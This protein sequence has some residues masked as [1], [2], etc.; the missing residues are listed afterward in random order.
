MPYRHYR[1][2]THN[3]SLPD[4]EEFNKL[5][6]DELDEEKLHEGT[7]FESWD[8][9]LDAI[10]VYARRCGFRLRKGRID[11]T[12]DGVIRKRTVL[13]EHS[14]E[15]KPR[16]TLV[17]K[18]STKYIKCQ[19]H[20]N[21]SQP[22]QNNP[23]GNV[24]VTTIKNEHN[25]ELSSFRVEFLDNSMLTQQML[26][27]IEFYV[28]DVGL[29][30][31]Q[32]Q[33]ALQKEFPD[34]EIY[35]PE[36]HKVMA[37]FHHKKRTDISNDAASLYESLLKRKDNDPRW[38]IAIDWDRET[39]CLRR[40]FWMSPE[41]I[42]LWMEFGDIILNDNTAKTNRYDMALS[43]FL[44]IDNHGSSRL[45]GCAL[46]DDES[47]DAH[48][49][50][51]HQ[52]KQATGNCVP[53]VIMTDADPALDLAIAEEYEESYAMHCIFHIAQNLPRNLET[54]LGEQ[55]REFVKDFY[56]TRNALVPEIFECKWIQLI[57]KYNQPE[58]VR[59]LQRTLYSSKRAWARAYTATVFTAGIQTTSRIESYN[60]QIKR[61]ILNS[62]V[63]LLELAE[64]L[65]RSMNEESKRAKYKYWKT[66]F[67]STSSATLSQTLF[68]KLDETLCHFLTPTM[69]KVQ[70]AEI[71][72]CL[73]YQASAITQ[74]DIIEYQE[75]VIVILRVNSY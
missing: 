69:L 47:A 71:K 20:V 41:Q 67:P 53:A 19:W 45:V 65:E 34:R 9:A 44:C 6:L 70:C 28:N 7:V 62:N 25:H 15:Y 63:S 42:I 40:L 74:E 58:V 23:H 55:Y 75:V 2:M 37:K 5:T 64:A 10:G 3:D 59:Y 73:N 51:L 46:T 68:P 8:K 27:R 43:L 14:G 18:A 13:C 21:L 39:H 26:E 4:F 35:L 1:K 12:P 66:L 52:T 36:I 48:R 61:F 49:W 31:L 38:Y 50:I 29:K 16:N 56:I 72:N 11:K 57:E 17:N 30:P 54:R 22:I 33:K 60:A 24:Y 32:V